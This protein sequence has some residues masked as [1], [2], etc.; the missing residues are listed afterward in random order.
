MRIV[1]AL[2]IS[3]LVAMAG[4]HSPNLTNKHCSTKS[5]KCPPSQMCDTATSLCVPIVL[6]P[7]DM[8]T[9]DISV[10]SDLPAPDIGPPIDLAMGA[11]PGA[12]CGGNSECLSK[13][14]VDGYCCDVACNGQCQA[15]DITPGQCA[16][17][18]GTPH[19]ARTAC[20]GSGA[21][22]GACGTQPT[23][24][25][26]PSSTTSCGQQMCADSVETLAT[27]C[28]GTGACSPA[29]TTSC[30]AFLCS[31]N[32]CPTSCTGDGQCVPP[33][34]CIGGVCQGT[35]PN[36]AVCSGNGDCSSGF[37]VDGVCCNIG[38][39][40]ECQACDVSGAVGICTQVSGAP[41]GARTPCIGVGSGCGGTCGTQTTQCDYPT[42]SCRS[43]SCS[44]ANNTETLAASCSKGTC[45]LVQTAGCGLY[46][47]GASAC[48]ATCKGDGDCA[49]GDFCNA[50]TCLATA[51]LG[52]S[53]SPS[54]VCGSGNCVDGYC[55]NTACTG[56]CEQCDSTPGTCTQVAGTPHGS[57]TPCINPGAI[58][59]G[60]CGSSRTMCDYA[61]ISKQCGSTC[62]SAATEGDYYC[63]G[64]GACGTS[65]NNVP[66][67]NSYACVT[68]P[69]D[70][71]KTSCGVDSDCQPGNI[72]S[73]GAC[74]AC[75]AQNQA[76]CTG[77]ECNSNLSCLSGSCQ[78]G[79]VGQVCCG[80][81]TCNA[82]GLCSGGSCVACGGTNQPCCAGSSCGSNL[83]CSGGLCQCGYQ[84]TPCCGGTSCVAGNEVCVGGTSCKFCGTIGN[85]CCSGNACSTGI[86]NVNTGCVPC[87][88]SGQP[89]CLP[90]P[91]C[92]SGLTCLYNGSYYCGVDPG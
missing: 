82:G 57:R 29:P 73:G 2:T 64:T 33:A 92:N 36:T 20:S 49:P 35:L 67:A 61:P 30:G 21:C 58:C 72:C 47:C 56:Q 14:C 24:C 40:G 10:G 3:L 53:C 15:C 90:H 91:G 89:C 34:K 88:A 78:C 85:P 19:G 51:P 9:R 27:S 66:C 1:T 18:S 43:A 80:G 17:V 26:Y 6:A 23:A 86:C 68:V 63:T 22:S 46:S 87:G 84:N 42:T 75:G 44:V 48:N 69:D 12:A 31:G 32:A 7:P 45:P 11:A 77:S 65:T 39:T 55:C 81:S 71:C 28:D 74:V 62:L 4:C 83:T 60:T 50:G 41:H 79:A 16:Q 37:C 52:H 76:C 70:K 13:F 59:G 25:D 54:I 8:A 38:C 5:P